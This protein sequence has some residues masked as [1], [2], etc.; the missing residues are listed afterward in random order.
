MS[1]TI[2]PAHS[3]VGFSAKHL[4][5]STVRGQ[6]KK[7][8][9]EIDLD[10]NDPTTASGRA[11]IDVASIDTGN[12]QR[13]GHLRTG[14]FFEVEKYPTI[15]FDLK[16]VEKGDDDT[17]KVTGALTI[18]GVTKDVVLD[19]EHAGSATDPYGN[20]KAGGSLTGTINRTDWD[21]KWNVPLGGGGLLVSERIKIEVEYQLAEAKEAVLEG[22]A[23]ESKAAETVSS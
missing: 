8:D 23:A 13:D 14:D 6:F 9:G 12:E 19:Y 18:K 5:L 22:A 11:T 4:G 10:P 7:F 21:L 20:T 2:D 15:T 1:W 16:Q 3:T 17:Y